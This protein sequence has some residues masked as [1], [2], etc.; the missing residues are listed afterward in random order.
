MKKDEELSFI[1]DGRLMELVSVVVG[2]MEKARANVDESIFK[3]GVDAFS[4]IFGAIGNKIN[5]S[6]WLEQERVIKSQKTLQNSIGIFH[7]SILGSVNGWED[8]GTGQIV[9]IKNEKR[10]IFAEIK[11]KHNTTKGNHKVAIYDDF[12]EKLR[13]PE[14]EGYVGYYVEIIPKNGQRYDKPFTPSDNRKGKK[15]PVNKKIRVIDGYS[16]YELATG[17]KDALIKLYRHLPSII[18]V[19]AQSCPEYVREDPLFE[20]LFYRAYQQEV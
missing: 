15:R 3:N 8:L 20:E 6:D 13:K 7:Q 5:L 18:C 1:S 16:F 9:D 11:N 19:V 12:K 2:V 17:E 10:K 14:Y 4:A